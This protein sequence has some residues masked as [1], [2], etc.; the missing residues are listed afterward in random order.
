MPQTLRLPRLQIGRQSAGFVQRGHPWVRQDRFTRGLD[1][2]ASGQAVT[3][4]DEHG[5][6]L[7]S[8]LVD[9]NHASICARVYHRSPDKPFAW[10]MA[11]KRAL[12]LRDELIKA[13]DLGPTTCYRV[14][15]GEGDYLPG[16]R[17][18]RLGEWLLVYVRAAAIGPYAEDIARHIADALNIAPRQ[19][20]I[21]EH[22]EDERRTPSAARRLDKGPLDPE[23]RALAHELG[24]P[25][26]VEPA[27]RLASGIYVDQRGTREWLIPR[28]KDQRVLNLFAYSGLFST[29]CLR[30]GAAQATS[31]DLSAPALSLAAANGEAAG[32]SDR[33]QLVHED[34]RAF[35]EATTDTYDIVICDPPTAAQGAGGW[36]ARRDYPLLLTA[37]RRC[38]QPGGLLIACVNTL[39]S[40]YDLTAALS[41]AGFSPQSNTLGPS[42]AGDIPQ[43]KGF[44]EG[45][46]FR[47][48][49]AKAP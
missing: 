2:L 9:R 38:M 39:G 24:V 17:I 3:L 49:V 35:C 10:E 7:A 25:L 13:S 30:A 11:A 21:R 16:L 47:L 1:A 31:V 46:P 4:V 15:H 20:V 33:H 19:V 12:A 23:Q 29:C 18:E 6:G 27:A 34:C 8:A 43:R 22:V 32:V 40:P 41:G 37:I 36:L 28:V 45:R 44:A 5:K 14:V 48:V 42:L 26:W